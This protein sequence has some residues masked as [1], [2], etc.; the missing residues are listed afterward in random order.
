MFW[1]RTKE[2]VPYTALEA[3]R[4]KPELEAEFIEWDRRYTEAMEDVPGSLGSETLAPQLPEQPEWIVAARWASQED[5]DRFGASPLYERFESEGARYKEEK[6]VLAVDASPDPTGA[7]GE[8][9]PLVGGN[10]TDT[11]ICLTPLIPTFCTVKSH[12]IDLPAAVVPP[13][14]VT[15]MMRS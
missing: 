7:G 14:S 4:V 6:S 1:S 5:M 11:K 3:I 2:A 9:G 8:I 13:P 15:Y 10:E 12:S